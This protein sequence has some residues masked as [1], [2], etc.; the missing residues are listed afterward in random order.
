[1]RRIRWADV[2]FFDFTASIYIFMKPIFTGPNINLGQ[3]SLFDVDLR[4]QVQPKVRGQGKVTGRSLIEDAEDILE[5]E[6]VAEL[7]LQGKGKG[8]SA[9]QPRE[10]KDVPKNAKQVYTSVR[11]MLSGQLI[12][13]YPVRSSLLARDVQDL[14]RRLFVISSRV[15]LYAS[16]ALL[17]ARPVRSGAGS[18]NLQRKGQGIPSPR[19]RRGLVEV[20]S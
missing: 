9:P 13:I 20:R 11:L 3:P 7:D 15:H 4:R 5:E 1:M 12:T 2:R 8:K 17:I 6:V 16:N 19:R 18:G 14:P 10:P